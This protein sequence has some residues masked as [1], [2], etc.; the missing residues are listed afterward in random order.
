MFYL[1]NDESSMERRYIHKGTKQYLKTNIAFFVAGFNTFTILYCVQPLL[2]NFSQ[3]YELSPTVASLALSL[4]TIA[5]A[6]AML[7]FGSLSDAVGRKNVMLYSMIAASVICLFI[8][9]SPTFTWLLVLRTIQGIALAGLPSVAMAYLSEEISP[10]SL[11]AAMGL[12]ICGNA[13]GA[14]FGRMFSGIVTEAANWQSALFL[15]G[16]IS[17]AASILFAFFLPISS[18]FRP[19]KRQVPEMIYSLKSHLGNTR[20]LCLFGLGFILL[21]TN[22]ALFNYMGFTL[23]NEPYSVS[24]TIVSS[25]FLLFI[26]GMFS[27]VIAGKLVDSVGKEKTVLLSLLIIL[28]GILLTLIPNLAF[29]ICG[30]AM[31]VYG[32]FSSHSVASSWVGSIVSKNKAQAASLYLFFYYA[33]SSVIGTLGGILWATLD[34]TG[35]AWVNIIFILIGF[36]LMYVL[37]SQSNSGI[38]KS[39][40]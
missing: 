1:E 36:L 37:I 4:T 20:L 12:Y 15:V 8:P 21:G 27:S 11:G 29:K 32:F 17:L 30:T 40:L 33:G 26:I 16:V 7:F 14:T 19:T 5:L 22:V 6:I 23:L 2:P 34:W 39:N 31:S 38:K 10:K 35:V 9:L 13:L 24:Q 28:A 3:H 25:I 18:N